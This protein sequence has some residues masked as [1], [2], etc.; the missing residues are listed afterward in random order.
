MR[1]EAEG[2]GSG[3]E[4]E[5]CVYWCWD[6]YSLFGNTIFCYCLPARYDALWFMLLI[7]TVFALLSWNAEVIDM[8]TWGRHRLSLPPLFISSY[9]SSTRQSSE[10]LRLT[11]FDWLINWKEN[12]GETFQ[13][14]PVNRFYCWPTHDNVTQNGLSWIEEW[15]KGMSGELRPDTAQTFGL[16]S[17]SRRDN[18]ALNASCADE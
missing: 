1:A 8:S 17:S 9:R 7:S 2:F 18:T 15:G 3:D 14:L 10:K 4:I 5:S 13:P 11:Y 6:V 12:A 16:V